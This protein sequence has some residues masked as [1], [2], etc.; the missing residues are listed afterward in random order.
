MKKVLMV[1]LLA[2]SGCVPAGQPMGYYGGPVAAPAAN[3]G[4]AV[5]PPPFETRTPAAPRPSF[6]PPPMVQCRRL[7]GGTV[8]CQ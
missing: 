2:A 8:Q 7:L 6:A 1:A 3:A 5:V 4:W